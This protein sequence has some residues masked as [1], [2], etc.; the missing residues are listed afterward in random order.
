MFAIFQ[1]KGLHTRWTNV[2][3]YSRRPDTTFLSNSHCI[4]TDLKSMIVDDNE[5]ATEDIR[6]ADLNADGKIDIVAAGRA[7]HNLKIYFNE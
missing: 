4:G 6:V 2:V 7:S 5:M 1:L 3:E